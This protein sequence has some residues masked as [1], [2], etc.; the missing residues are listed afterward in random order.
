MSR[1]SVFS[2]SFLLLAAS[3][4]AQQPAQVPAVPMTQKLDQVAVDAS[5][6][7]YLTAYQ[8]K[9]IQELLAVWPDLQNQKKDYGK[10]KQQFGDARVSDVQ[11]SVT[12]LE[13]QATA[14]GAMVHAQRKEQ[15]VKT[16]SV[17]VNTIGDNRAG[18]M[19]GQDMGPHETERKKDVKK[20]DE[21]WFKLHQGAD[22]WTIV[23]ITPQKPQ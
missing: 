10:I 19:P 9:N 15:F 3:T 8:H 1:I 20:N 11:M 13:V 12:P 5:L 23:S 17:S 21:V 16:E 7:R 22:N 2:F 18:G 14:D 4:L 6:Q